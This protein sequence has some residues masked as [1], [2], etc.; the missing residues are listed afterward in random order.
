[1]HAPKNVNE[2]AYLLV[3]NKYATY[4]ELTHEY[5]LK[6]FIELYEICMVNLYNKALMT[7]AR[8]KK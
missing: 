1:M 2:M 8:D 5:D 3:T 7:E 6:E 4:K